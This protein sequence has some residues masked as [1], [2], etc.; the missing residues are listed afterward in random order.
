MASA[1]LTTTIT[2]VAIVL[3]ALGSSLMLISNQFNGSMELCKNGVYILPDLQTVIFGHLEATLLW[4]IFKSY[5]L[6]TESV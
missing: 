5:G 4:S 2:I 3:Y 6:D 1:Q